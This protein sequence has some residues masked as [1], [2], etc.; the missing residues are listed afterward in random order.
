MRL[1]GFTLIELLVVVAIIAILASMLMPAFSAAKSKVHGAGCLNNLRQVQ[2]AFQ[3]YSDDTGTMPMNFEGTRNG[4]WQSLPGSWV[5]GNARSDASNVVLHVGTLYAYLNADAVYR[6]PSDRSRVAGPEGLPR[7]RSY[8]MSLT[9]NGRFEGASPP[10][11][12]VSDDNL[13]GKEPIEAAVR[14]YG[15]IEVSPETIDAGSFF[16]RGGGN[17][18]DASTA[19]GWNWFHLPGE[20]HGGGA[21]LS[22]L[23][24]HVEHHQWLFKARRSGMIEPFA[25]EDDRE[26]ARWILR[27]TPWHLWLERNHP[28]AVQ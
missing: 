7:L 4:N 20:R 16:F 27:R 25:N 6:C 17:F 26:D 11:Y 19:Y 9:L 2:L 10:N 8:S 24:G 23:D 28:E 22:F 5:T 15:F 18:V 1:R 12:G 13:H 14:L 3:L 21:N